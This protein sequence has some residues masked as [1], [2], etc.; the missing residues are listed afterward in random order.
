MGIHKKIYTFLGLTLIFSTVFYYLI[1]SKE[2]LE[3]AGWLVFGLMWAPGISAIVTKLILDKT[4]LGL[5]WSI[6]KPKYLLISLAF[7]IVYSLIPYALVWATGLG[8]FNPT[9]F[10]EGF[11]NF[12]A[13]GFFM[14]CLAALGE[15][16][17][18]RGFL[19]PQLFKLMNFTKT[20][21]LSGA[22]WAL[23]HTPAILL[24]SYNNGANQWYSLFMFYIIATGVSFG[25]AWL[26]LRSGSVWTAMLIHGMHNNFVQ[27]YLD[28]VTEDTG[29]TAYVTGE[30][31]AALAIS[32]VVI[33]V[34]FWRL[35][36]KVENPE[37]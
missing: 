32:A 34:I 6:G 36:A 5:G 15:E 27:G 18:W 31:G 29:I 3:D 20:S 14:A 35:R 1:L 21:L 17:G 12:I 2:S 25:F 13:S 23:W 30:F 19:V 16:I 22:I 26:R 4:L 24:S 28:V 33:A 10:E 9:N 8:G 37:I 11:I 7:P